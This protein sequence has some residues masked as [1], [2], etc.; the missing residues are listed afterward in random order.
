MLPYRYLT[1]HDLVRGSCISSNLLE[2][3]AGRGRLGASQLGQA[4]KAVAGTDWF[5]HVVL[6]EGQGLRLSQAQELGCA[7]AKNFWSL[8]TAGATK[9]PNLTDFLIVRFSGHTNGEGFG[10]GSTT[11]LIDEAKAL[12]RSLAAKHNVVKVAA[13]VATDGAGAHELILHGGW[14]WL[15][16]MYASPFLP[17]YEAVSLR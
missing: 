16:L 4:L 7:R 3:R 9:Q 2:G 10:V 8:E 13:L 14:W 1:T 5:G 6:V 12:A 11:V 15:R 17:I